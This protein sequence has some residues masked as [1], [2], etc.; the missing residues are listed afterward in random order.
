MDKEYN[1][2]QHVW[3][4]EDALYVDAYGCCDFSRMVLVCS[5]FALARFL[6]TCVFSFQCR[7][8]CSARISR[9]QG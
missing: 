6:G 1:V 8:R 7:L 2:N 5:V 3:R 9:W 4:D